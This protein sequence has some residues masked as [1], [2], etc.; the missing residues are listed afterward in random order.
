M[1]LGTVGGYVSSRVYKSKYIQIAGYIQTNK[2]S[3]TMRV[4]KEYVCN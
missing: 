4:P 1:C 2:K 3:P